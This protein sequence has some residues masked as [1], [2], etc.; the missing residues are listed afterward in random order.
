MEFY[1]NH[2]MLFWSAL[3]FFLFLT[4]QIAILPAITN[5]TVYKPLPDAKPLTKMEKAGKAVYV[6]NGCIACHTQQVREVE[7]D[8][9]F[10]GRPSI[11]AD[12]AQNHRMDV[13]RNTPNLL[14]S[15]RTGP[16]LTAI[17]ERQPSLDWHLLEYPLHKGMQTLV[18]DLNHLYRTETALYENNFSPEG[19]EWVEANDDNNSVYI[20]LRKAKE[21]AEVMMIVLN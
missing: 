12:Y 10:G 3:V 4:L 11:P 14:G 9:V 18:K 21:E 13:W 16:D 7:M 5:Q 6:E 19:F 15:E 1:N 2:K 17:G 20:Y 8:K